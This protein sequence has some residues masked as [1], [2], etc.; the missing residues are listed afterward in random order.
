MGRCSGGSSRAKGVLTLLAT[1]ALSACSPTIGDGE[2]ASGEST[3]TSGGSTQTSGGSTQV[4]GSPATGGTVSPSGGAPATAGEGNGAATSGGTGPSSGGTNG[5]GGSVQTGLVTCGEGYAII[6]APDGLEYSEKNCFPEGTIDRE[7]SKAAFMEHVY[8]ILL[9]ACSRC[10][11]STTRRQAPMHSDTANQD[12]AH[13]SALTK[14]NPYNPATSRLVERLGI[15]RHNCFGASCAEAGQKMLEAVTKWADAVKPSLPPLVA[16]VPTGTPFPEE[17][18]IALIDADVA[19]TPEA[20]RKYIKY[21]SLHAAQNQ[22]LGAEQMDLVRVALAKALNSTA[23]W[24]PELVMP[25]DVSGGKGMVY[26]FDIRD[27]WGYQKGEIDKLIF[28]G[29]DDDLAFSRQPVKYADGRSTSGFSQVSTEKLPFSGKPDLPLE[30]SADVAELV[31][32]RIQAGNVEGAIADGA[33]NLP[34]NTDGFKPKYVEAGQLVYT[35][36]RPD[37][38]NSIMHIPWGGPDLERELGLDIS[39]GPKSFDFVIVKQAIT[40]D[41]RLLWRGEIDD[42]HGGKTYYWKTADVF[43]GQ[44]PNGIRDIDE[45]YKAGIIRFPW[46]ANP[47]PVWI[48]G[49]LGSRDR[50]EFSF[51]AS[52]AQTTNPQGDCD[53]QPNFSGIQGFYNCRHFTGEGGLQ[54]SALEVIWGMPNGM[55]GYVL[56]GATNQRRVDA[57]TNIVRDYRILRKEI[58][59]DE[60]RQEASDF[61]IQ[62]ET[63][64]FIPEKRLNT[65]SSC[66]GCH[67]DGMNR[68][69]NDLRD[70]L[71]LKESGASDP[72]AANYIQGKYGVDTWIDDPEKVAEVKEYYPPS[73]ELRPKQER[74][75]LRFL[76]AE[77]KLKQAM[78][79]SPLKN[80][81]MDSTMFTIEWARKLYR[82]P[83]TRSN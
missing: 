3:Q 31:W 33:D 10:H 71:D 26:R 18:V 77:G 51:L 46:W 65:G 15:D 21:A 57:F 62:A 17:D 6:K 73:S 44:L 8:P 63:D 60:L 40:I 2:P 68:L 48:D 76:K 39:Q 24:A 11:S 75:R 27:Y 28:G 43:T 23:R 25:K 22:G 38:Y 36:T 19:A 52:L 7:A 30:K 67:S 54:Q 42:G 69:D 32:A 16:S 79:S 78:M 64:F 1:A 14:L 83:V 82:Y 29:S 61:Q 13:E 55:Q 9:G 74:D 45:A 56:Y 72:F 66:I 59:G 12:L 50:T 80:T 37:V 20:D 58:L 5:T 34:P 53:P 47:I 4:A 35:L 81:G 49:A 41:A 70:W